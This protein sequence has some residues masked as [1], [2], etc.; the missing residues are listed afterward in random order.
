MS[1]SFEVSEV[2]SWAGEVLLDATSEVGESLEL[3]CWLDMPARVE[4]DWVKYSVRQEGN[5]FVYCQRNICKAELPD[6]DVTR[7]LDRKCTAEPHPDSEVYK[8]VRWIG[9]W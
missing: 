4:V 2:T 9:E 5:A 3:E 1:K 6:S 7:S 8:R